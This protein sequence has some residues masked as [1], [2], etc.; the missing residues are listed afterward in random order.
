MCAYT[1]NI[2]SLCVSFQAWLHRFVRIDRHE[3][4]QGRWDRHPILDNLQ[5]PAKDPPPRQGGGPRPHVHGEGSTDCSEGCCNNYQ[6]FPWQNFTDLRICKVYFFINVRSSNVLIFVICHYRHNL[7][8]NVDLLE[9]VFRMVN[10]MKPT[11]FRFYEMALW[12]AATSWNVSVHSIQ[13]LGNFFHP[14]PVVTVS[15][16]FHSFTLKSIQESFQLYFRGEQRWS[17]I[18]LC[19]CPILFKLKVFTVLW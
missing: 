5:S 1:Q 8:D 4:R 13:L 19:L 17:H 18:L 6:G 2:N 3:F 16:V 14:F 9:R 7:V 11:R 10:D 15:T 12:F